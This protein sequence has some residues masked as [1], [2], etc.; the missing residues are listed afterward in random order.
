VRYY[1]KGAGARGRM[2]GAVAEAL[3]RDG[4][5]GRLA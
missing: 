5:K 3:Y 1:L 4:V 2:V